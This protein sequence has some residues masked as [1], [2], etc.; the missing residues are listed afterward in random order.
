MI[1]EIVVS[2]MAMRFTIVEVACP[3]LPS[4]SGDPKAKIEPPKHHFGSD[5]V[6]ADVSYGWVIKIGQDGCGQAGSGWKS[7]AVHSISQSSG[8]LRVATQRA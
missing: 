1:I 8:D 3:G 4:V 6:W 2:A 5:Q 7:I